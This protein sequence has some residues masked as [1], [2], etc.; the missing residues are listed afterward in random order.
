[1]PL[2]FLVLLKAFIAVLPY[3]ISL[4]IPLVLVVFTDWAKQFFAWTTEQGAS[5]ILSVLNTL[6][7]PDVDI[8]LSNILASIPSDVKQVMGMLKV[9]V[10]IGMIISAYITFFAVKIYL[11]SVASFRASLSSL[12]NVGN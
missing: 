8:S 6:T 11:K 1:M 10:F 9:D 7:P 12:N 2:V 5:V 3:L 4:V